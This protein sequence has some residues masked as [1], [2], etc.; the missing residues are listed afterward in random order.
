MTTCTEALD[1]E[2][3]GSIRVWIVGLSCPGFARCFLQDTKIPELF[4]RI[5]DG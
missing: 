3:E 2:K 1:F 5:R 4:W